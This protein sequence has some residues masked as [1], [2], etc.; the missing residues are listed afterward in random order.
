MVKMKR[1]PL[2][3]LLLVIISATIQL[4]SSAEADGAKQ[5]A[6]PLDK[7]LTSL[8]QPSS[9]QI[10]QWVE[11]IAGQ[12]EFRSWQGAVTSIAPIGPGQHGWL[13]TVYVKKQPV[14]YLI[15]NA[16]EDGGYALG[17]Y[18]A[19]SHPL[20]D[21][22]TLYQSLIR[23][24][25]IPSYEYATKKPLKLERLY[26]H[27]LL[28]VWRWQASDG[29]THYLDGWTGES[30]PIDDKIWQAAVQQLQANPAKTNHLPLLGGTSATRIS[31]ALAL[32][33]FDVYER[34]PWLTGSPLTQ[35]AGLTTLMERKQNIRY[36]AELYDGSVLF[37]WPAIGYQRWDTS[38]LFI[39]FE[40]NGS[41]YIALPSLTDNGHFFN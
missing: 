19:G 16:K 14:G 5:S 39:A 40:Q 21:P 29:Q 8:S 4:S 23:Q 6:A 25:L 13:V 2:H 20:F 7:T 24:N 27:P 28:A 37:V 15:V 38:D 26:A 17:E 33:S 9:E 34:M 18:G 30:L 31:K 10:K 3:I 32:P 35:L 11:A 36:T 22:N 41:R 12:P 1:L